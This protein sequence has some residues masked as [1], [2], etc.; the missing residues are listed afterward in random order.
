MTGTA[1]ISSCKRYRYSLTRLVGEGKKCCLF[2]MLNPS[3]AD[4]ETDDPTIR[5]CKNYAKSW[6]CG[7]LMVVNLFAFR[8]M[9]PSHMM[10]ANEPVG[11]Y[12]DHHIRL[13]LAR[14]RGMGGVVVCGWGAHGGFLDRD[15]QVLEILRNEGV[16]PSCLKQT[17]TG[18][19]CHPLYLAKDLMPYP[20]EIADGC[21]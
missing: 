19:P 7:E 16:T 18:Q 13:G 12:N 4:A 17:N 6:G 1:I 21:C 8:A 20:L 11:E 14:V 2:I 5:R 10:A 15:K 9:N 3:T